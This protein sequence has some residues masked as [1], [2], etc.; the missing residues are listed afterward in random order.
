MK[1]IYADYEDFEDYEES[2][3]WELIKSKSVHDSDGFLTE[4]CLYYNPVEDLYVT[5]FGD[6]D[7]YRPE[8]GDFDAEFDSEEQAIEWF[9]NYNGFDDDIVDDEE[10]NPE[11]RYSVEGYFDRRFY[12]LAADLD[13]DDWSKATDAA[14]EYL[15]NGYYTLIFDKKTGE[16]IR[17]TPDEYFEDFNGEFPVSPTDLDPNYFD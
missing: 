13:T 12:G 17:L 3:D 8:D 5:V 15:S 6:S 9:D 11:E 10:V 1:R 4:Y 7:L 2:S 14:H 16:E